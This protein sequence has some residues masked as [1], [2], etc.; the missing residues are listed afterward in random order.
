VE[1]AKDLATRGLQALAGFVKSLKVTYNDIQVGLDYEP[2]AGL[3]DNGDLEQDLQA[4]LE[5]VGT[6]AKKAGTAIVLFIDELQYVKEDQLAA[7]ISALHLCAQRKLPVC[8][9][10]QATPSPM[11]SGFSTSLSSAR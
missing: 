7:L 10:S 2:Q 11:P 5:I 3:A 8:A 9:V 4:L 6:A 1:G